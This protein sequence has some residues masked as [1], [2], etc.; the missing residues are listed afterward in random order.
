M[1]MKCAGA[2]NPAKTTLLSAQTSPDPSLYPYKQNIPFAQEAW[3]HPT[4]PS[5][6]PNTLSIRDTPRPSGPQQRLQF[7]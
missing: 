6:T 5:H 1:A 4:P 7:P 3:S 2:I